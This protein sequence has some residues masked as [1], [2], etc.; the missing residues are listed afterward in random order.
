M[1]RSRFI[2]QPLAFDTNQ[3][4]VGAFDVVNFEFRPVGV[5]E[6]KLGNIPMQMFLRAQLIDSEHAAFE[7][8]V[9]AL[10]GIDCDDCS[11][12]AI[13]VGIFL[14]AVVDNVMIGEL[15]GQLGVLT[16]LVS[17]NMSFFRDMRLDDW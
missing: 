13:S 7:N 5:S 16:G 9:V 11:G 15:F 3:G 8:R 2:S 14:S 10:S 6:I 12:L 1:L 17:H 4:S